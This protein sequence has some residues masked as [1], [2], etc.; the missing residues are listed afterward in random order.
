MRQQY[1]YIW[2]AFCHLC[3]SWKTV[4]KFSI[5]RAQQSFMTNI[6]CMWT[7]TQLKIDLFRSHRSRLTSWLDGFQGS[8]TIHRLQSL[9]SHCY[10]TNLQAQGIATDG[11]ITTPKAWEKWSEPLSW[12]PAW[13][14]SPGH[15]CCLFALFPTAIGLTGSLKPHW[16]DPWII[17][18]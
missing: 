6:I 9:F 11:E 5:Q 7:G 1:L 17:S 13:T 18:R 3:E 15:K 4:P 8:K 2:Q 14:P 12:I 10:S 16:Q